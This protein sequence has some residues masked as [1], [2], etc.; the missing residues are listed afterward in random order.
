MTSKIL[1]ISNNKAVRHLLGSLTS[2][3]FDS[4]GNGRLDL[5]AQEWL[6][7]SGYKSKKIFLYQQKRGG[8]SLKNSYALRGFKAI[9]PTVKAG[10]VNSDGINDLIIYDLGVKIGKDQAYTGIEPTIFYGR[11]NKKPTKSNILSK[12][13][14]AYAPSDSWQVDGRVS[15]KDFALADIDNDGDLD[16][17]VESTGGMNLTNHFLINNGSHFTVDKERIPMKDIQGEKATDFKRY[18]AAH[19]DDLNGDGSKDLILGQSRTDNLTH[20]NGTSIVLQNNRQGFFSLNKR[21]PEPNFNNGFTVASEITSGDLNNDGMIDIVLAHRRPGNPLKSNDSNPGTGNYIQILIQSRHGEFIDHTDKIIGPQS[22]W[23]NDKL[24][25]TNFIANIDFFDANDDGWQDLLINYWSN[26]E[27]VGPTLLVNKKGEK[28]KNSNP[29]SINNYNGEFNFIW[30]SDQIRKGKLEAMTQTADNEVL[31]IDTLF[32]RKSSSLIFDE[33]GK[34]F[35]KKNAKQISILENKS[36]TLKIS[37]NTFGLDRPATFASGK[38]KKVIKK[39]LS[40]QHFDFLYDRQEGLLYF[41]EN[42]S[43]KGFGNG[44]ILAIVKGAP[45][46]SSSNLEFI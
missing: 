36:S 18:W 34:K 10:D 43:E 1:S 26:F 13:Y 29:E 40:K 15:A 19:F 37:I 8:K 23:S 44:G 45:E 30:N 16:I 22:K 24:N 41:N 38:N 35:T 21:L 31:F 7:D 32:K 3:V 27:I 12:A 46:L 28:L 25:N 6:P 42:G 4:N 14:S 9:T 2:I 5:L 33:S 39:K 11:R 17:W 20:I